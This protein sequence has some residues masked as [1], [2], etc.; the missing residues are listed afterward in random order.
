MGGI[1][2]VLSV[3]SLH[4]YTCSA[5]S[6]REALKAERYDIYGNTHCGR[7]FGLR[8]NEDAKNM[9]VASGIRSNLRNGYRGATQRP[10]M[11]RRL[12]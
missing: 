5:D 3:P 7:Q 4:R 9:H 10:W 12:L 2:K 8:T 11:N 1:V 6:L